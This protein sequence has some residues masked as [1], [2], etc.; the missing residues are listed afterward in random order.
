MAEEIRLNNIGKPRI[1]LLPLMLE[2]YRKYAPVIQEKQKPFI[3]GV[4]E[5]LRKFSDVSIAPVCTTRRETEYGLRKLEIEGIDLIVVIFISYATSISALGPLLNMKLPVLLFSTAP[6]S[7][8]AEGM[9]MEDI[10]L[11]HGVHGYMDLANV[12]KRNM[13]RFQFVCGRMD[14]RTALAEIEACLLYTSD[15][16]DE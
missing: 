2:M 8:M 1:G 3:Q 6:K 5:R 13:R 10:M 16:A 12:L 7:S 4:A 15:A 9:T 11:N 14:D